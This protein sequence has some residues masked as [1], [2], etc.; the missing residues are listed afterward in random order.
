M[1]AGKGFKP[2]IIGRVQQII[3]VLGEILFFHYLPNDEVYNQG[4]RLTNS[5]I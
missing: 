1:P 3:L 2:I 4:V 5:L